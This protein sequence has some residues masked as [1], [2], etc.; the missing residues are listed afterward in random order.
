MKV[1]GYTVGPVAENCFFAAR[2]LRAAGFDV[3]MAEDASAG[4]DVPAAGL[5]Q[6]AAKAEGEG[7]GIRYATVAEVEK[8]ME[9]G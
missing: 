8:T 5:F 4:I 3:W 6:A 9:R 7:L 2:D 1:H